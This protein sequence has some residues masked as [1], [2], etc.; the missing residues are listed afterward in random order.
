VDALLIMVRQVVVIAEISGS[1]NTHRM[2]TGEGYPRLGSPGREKDSPK[3]K[4]RKVQMEFR[5]YQC[6]NCVKAVAYVENDVCVESKTAECTKK[7]PCKIREIG[8]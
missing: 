4:H 5:S 6:H 3:Y 2:G 1:A 7:D 8:A